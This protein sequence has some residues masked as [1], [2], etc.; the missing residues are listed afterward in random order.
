M[1]SGEVRIYSLTRHLSPLAAKLTRVRSSLRRFEFIK[2]Q[3]SSFLR[4]GLFNLKDVTF[5][6][7]SAY[8]GAH[9]KE[10]VSRDVCSWNR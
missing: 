2:A 9:V 10:V 8:T 5:I 1:V 3:L 6:P 7:I 4:R